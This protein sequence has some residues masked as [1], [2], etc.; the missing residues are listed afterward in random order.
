[1]LATTSI[2]LRNMRQVKKR[3][4]ITMK[5]PFEIKG[6]TY[7]LILAYLDP[8]SRKLKILIFGLRYS[9][10]FIPLLT[11]M[12]CLLPSQFSPCLL[13][14]KARILCLESL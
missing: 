4:K 10:T 13:P 14:T 11:P 5:K 7:L 3:S 2:E 9:N 12:P 8:K 6:Q 1:M